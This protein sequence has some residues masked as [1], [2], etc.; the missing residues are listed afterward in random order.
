[1]NLQVKTP[2]IDASGVTDSGR[3]RPKNEDAIFLDTEGN[4]MLLADGMGGHERGSE[5]SQTAIEIIKK[6]LRPEVLEAEL[7]EITK[8]EGVPA[9]IICL[10]SIIDKAIGEANSVLF[11]RN[12]SANLKRYMGTTVVGMLPVTNDGYILW[13]HVG[14]SRLYRWR[15]TELQ[16]LTADHSAYA[17]WLR[18]GQ[19][20]D[21]PAKSIITRAIGPNAATIVDIGYEKQKKD[22]LYILCSDG[23]TDML[24]DDYIAEILRS[25]KDV[26]NIANTLMHAA[27]DA[28]GKDNISVVVSKVKD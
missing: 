11:E 28:G 24:S 19:H 7:K 26:D 9:A 13:F 27:N 10:H 4:F 12:Q 5:A 17:E 15:D 18:S 16:C 2:H 20:G 25:E 14:D 1:M 21:P 3:I 6:F 22:D 23:L 8:V